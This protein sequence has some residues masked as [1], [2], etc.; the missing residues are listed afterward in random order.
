MHQVLLQQPL[1]SF[2]MLPRA[3]AGRIASHAMIVEVEVRLL[4]RE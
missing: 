3:E 2:I 1:Y 4:I